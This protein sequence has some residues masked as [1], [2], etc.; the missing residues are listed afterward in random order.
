MSDFILLGNK[1]YPLN[2]LIN[3]SLIEILVTLKLISFDNLLGVT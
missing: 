2:T 3:L 1:D